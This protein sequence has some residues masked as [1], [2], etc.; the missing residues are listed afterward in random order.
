MG[1][2]KLDEGIIQSS[3]MAEDS[4]TFKVWIALLAICKENGIAYVSPVFLSSVCHIPLETIHGSIDKLSSPD[5]D[6]RST[7]DDGRRI[8]RVDGGFEIVNY[9]VYRTVSL[10]SADAERQ[11][12][13]R[14][15][16]NVMTKPDAVQ[17][18]H[19]ASA[20]GSSSLE[21]DSDSSSL[22]SLNSK[23][24]EKID[25]HAISAEVVAYLN[26]KADKNF[27]Y[28]AKETVRHIG[29]RIAD[30]RTIENFRHVIDVKVAKWKGKTWK[31]GK[32]DTVIGDDLLRPSTLFSQTNFENYLNESMPGVKHDAPSKFDG[33]GKEV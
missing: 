25:I 8:R 15:S 31:G 3:I 22:N 13:Y 12:L 9:L 32:G 27:D 28:K 30:G 14:A 10:R 19:D 29:A 26:T 16:K 11:R 5:S 17:E 24:K 33:L 18:C 7:S 23:D 4:D 2:T 20:S 6:S 21:S 1:F